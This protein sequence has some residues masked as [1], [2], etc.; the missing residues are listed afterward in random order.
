M[1]SNGRFV[2]IHIQLKY[3]EWCNIAKSYTKRNLRER[4]SWVQ[5]T[6]D[7]SLNN[8]ISSNNFVLDLYFKNL[9]AALHVFF[10]GCIKSN[11]GKSIL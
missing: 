7:I 10:I 3:I 11:V 8:V 1:Q 2:K 4:E 5:V 6:L 9:I